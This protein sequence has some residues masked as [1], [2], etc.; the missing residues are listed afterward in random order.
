MSD[1]RRA[2][3]QYALHTDQEGK[4]WNEVCGRGGPFLVRESPRSPE[5][6]Q[7]DFMCVS[8]QWLEAAKKYALMSESHPC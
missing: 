3:K 8:E 7:R 5:S 2:T 1:K 4:W 6:P